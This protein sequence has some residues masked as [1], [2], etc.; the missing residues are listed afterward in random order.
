MIFWYGK[1]IGGESEGVA[2]P[3]L[4]ELEQK[5]TSFSEKATFKDY[6]NYADALFKTGDFEMA[7]DIYQRARTFLADHYRISDFEDI[8]SNEISE[9]Y[10]QNYKDGLVLIESRYFQ[11]RDSFIVRVKD[12]ADRKKAEVAKCVEKNEDSENVE[13]RYDKDIRYFYNKAAEV[14]DVLVDSDDVNLVIKALIWRMEMYDFLQNNLSTIKH[15]YTG[16][17]ID[18]CKKMISLVE[19]CK[20]KQLIKLVLF[21]DVFVTA[22]RRIAFITYNNYYLKFLNQVSIEKSLSYLDEIITCL[23]VVNKVVGEDYSANYLLMIATEQKTML[24]KKNND[25]VNLK[26]SAIKSIELVFKLLEYLENS[27]ADNKEYLDRK[28][29]VGGFLIDCIVDYNKYIADSD[30]VLKRYINLAPEDAEGI[31]KIKEAMT[32][33]R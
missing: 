16:L 14:N 24:Y 22:K 19:Y 4:S 9:A 2:V 3:S 26:N 33:A 1:S 32:A 31:D 29:V 8:D 27:K 7:N 28:K 17:A 25:D 10:K 15:N 23:D 13:R 18:N 5:I 30:Q 20:E 11:Y 12:V 6:C 21:N